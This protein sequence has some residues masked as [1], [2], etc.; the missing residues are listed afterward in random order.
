MVTPL[1]KL[2]STVPPN[3]VVQAPPHEPPVQTSPIPHGVPSAKAVPVSVHV[4][5]PDAQDVVPTSH[6]LLGLHGAPAVHAAHEPSLQT[7]SVPHDVP[8]ATAVPVSVQIEAPDAQDVVPT[9][10]R[11]LGV[12][13][14]LAVH[15][16]HVPPLQTSLVPHDVPFATAVPV[17][18]H[19]GAPDTQDVAPTSHGLLGVHEA[20]AAHP[21]HEPLLQT[22]PIPHDVPSATASSVSVHVE[23]PDAQDV[24]PTSHGLPGVHEAPAAHA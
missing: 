21:P 3:V 24:A 20:P 14:A 13:E 11:L 1:S 19:V 22:S 10:H 15:A 18:V 2:K 12:H 5:A 16:E 8:F 4:E 9:S 7:S 23:V 17:S 6:G